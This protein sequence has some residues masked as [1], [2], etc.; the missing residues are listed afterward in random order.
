ME[1]VSVVTSLHFDNGFVL[2]SKP[3]KEQVIAASTHFAKNSEDYMLIYKGYSL[4][5]CHFTEK[6]WDSSIDSSVYFHANNKPSS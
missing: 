4:T 3:Y 1:R 2:S 6:Q 5:S